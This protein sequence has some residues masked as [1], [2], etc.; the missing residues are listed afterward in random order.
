MA[1]VVIALAGAILGFLPS[2][3]SPANIFMGDSG[4]LFIGFLLSALALTGPQKIT[5]M[6]GAAIPILIFGLP[7]LDVALAVARRS[8][9]GQSP[10][11]G[12]ADHVHHKLL[13][14][15]LTQ[16]HAA[17]VLYGVTVAFGLASLAV[18]LNA[19][20]LVPVLVAVVLCVFLGVRQ[21]GYVEFSRLPAAWLGGS[22]RREITAD[23]ARIL[24][25]A[26]S[27]RSSADFRAICLI[28]RETLQPLGFDGIRLKNTGNGHLPTK[29]FY[30]LE[31]D[32]ERRLMFTWSQWTT[33]DPQPG[34]WRSE[35]VISSHPTMGCVS[36][37]RVSAPDEDWQMKLSVLSE[38]FK[39]ALA[40]AVGRALI[41]ARLSRQAPKGTPK[42]RAVAA[43]R[44]PESAAGR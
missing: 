26:E 10:F 21:L 11:R 3:F 38:E 30:P 19:N 33:G 14:L 20:W 37:F 43:G 36:L 29:L 4:S 24:Y 7:I 32:S 25:A 22:Q 28:L 31:Y 42:A 39:T 41:S 35:L 15:G 13:K 44:S 6:A 1:I 27:L 12:D 16:S 18:T 34:E 2:N 23:Q 17:L 40:S 5:S 9:R 8:L